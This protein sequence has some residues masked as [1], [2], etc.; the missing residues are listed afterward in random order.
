VLLVLILLEATVPLPAC[1]P[2]QVSDGDADVVEVDFALVEA[3]PSLEIPGAA[4]VTV[5]DP[6]LHNV[7]PPAAKALPLV[8]TSAMPN[9]STG[10]EHKATAAMNLRNIHSTPFSPRGRRSSRIHPQRNERFTAVRQV[11]GGQH[12][13]TITAMLENVSTRDCTVGAIS[14]SLGE[15]GTRRDS[16]SWSP[17]R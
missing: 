12:V 5:W 4:K 6:P 16:N 7:V 2:V 15:C 1:F 8:E 3:V 17:D 11:C 10:T 9:E 14:W 13:I